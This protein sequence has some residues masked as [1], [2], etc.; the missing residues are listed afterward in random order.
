MLL[1]A[2]S[3][4]Y[5]TKCRSATVEWRSIRHR[6]RMS[7]RRLHR[8]AGPRHV[9]TSLSLANEPKEGCA[10]ARSLSVLPLL[11]MPFMTKSGNMESLNFA[12]EPKESRA[13]SLSVLLLPLLVMK[14]YGPPGRRRRRTRRKESW[15]RRNSHA[16][17]S[18]SGGQALL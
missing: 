13:R 8:H 3:Q 4:A 7:A 10:Y 15:P 5:R 14:C 12:N 17:L 16:Q 6:L 18:M 2:K 9:Q 1:G 11:V